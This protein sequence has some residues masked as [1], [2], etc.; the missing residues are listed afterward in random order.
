MFINHILSSIFHIKSLYCKKQ[1]FKLR[2]HDFELPLLLN[3]PCNEN[4]FDCFFGIL[5]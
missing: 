5:F 3:Q 2:F 4:C 1:L